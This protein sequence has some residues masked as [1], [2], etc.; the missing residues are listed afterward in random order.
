MIKQVAIGFLDGVDPIEADRWYFRYHYKE[1]LRFF[2]PWLRRYESYRAQEP[3]P[4]AERFGVRRGRLTELWYDSIESFIEAKPFSWPFTR[5]SFTRVSNNAQPAA[6]AMV[7]AMPTED[8]LGKAP[9]PEERPILRW[10]CVFRYPEGV[11]LEDGEKW[12][13]DVHSR[14][15]AQQ[16]GLLKYVSHSALK[17]SPMPSPWVRVS[18]LWYEDFD[19]WRKANIDSPPGFTSPPWADS[20]PFVELASTF[21]RYKPDVDFLKDNPLIP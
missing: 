21:V 7:P 11:S 12:Y 15:V 19:A 9:T 14:E 8:F 1:C 10:V 18:E 13:L 2:G 3:P 4:E 5:S 20:E 6:G 17:D 16:P